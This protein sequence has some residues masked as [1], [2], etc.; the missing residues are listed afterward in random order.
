MGSSKKLI[1]I[2]KFE[3][4]LQFFNLVTVSIRPNLQK[5]AA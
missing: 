4:N 2:E 5:L 1:K 3:G